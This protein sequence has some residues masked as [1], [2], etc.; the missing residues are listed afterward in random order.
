MSRRIANRGAARR[1]RS[2]QEND[3]TATPASH[4]LPALPNPNLC[5][6]R[7]IQSARAICARIFGYHADPTRSTAANHAQYLSESHPTA[8]TQPPTNLKSHNLCN[9]PSTVPSTL[10]KTLGL[11]LGFCLSLDRE[12]TNP[13]N[14]DRLRRD[15][16]TRY[17]VADLP[18][19]GYHPKLYVRNEEWEPGNAPPDVE[20]ALNA[21]ESRST[22][23]FHRSRLH[24]NQLSN[25]SAAALREI[26]AIKKEKK[27]MVTAT[28]KNL[29]PAIMETTLYIRRC[30]D[31]HLL[32][33][34]NYCELTETEALALNE[35]TYRRIL[36]HW[37]DDVSMDPD[38]R[39]YFERKL[40]GLRDTDGV[41]QQKEGL[42][43]QYFYIL[44]KVHKVPW[45]T[46]PVVSEVSSIQEALSVWI[47]VQLQ[48]V[49]HLCPAY[50]KDS[51]HF[52]DRLKTQPALPPESIIFTADAVGMYCNIN[53]DHA[54]DIMA[55]W[56]QLHAADIPASFP[57]KKVLTG[58]HIIMKSNVFTFGN[59]YWLQCNGTAMGTSCACAYATI[60]YSFHEET[61]LLPN[62]NVLFYGRLID[63]A[64]VVLRDGPD[65]YEQ[66]VSSMND[67]GPEG[68][69]LEWEAEPHSTTVN[70]LDLTVSLNPSG[71]FETSTFQKPM[72]LYLY[73]PPTSAQPDSILY[74]LVYG[75]LHRYFWQ[76]T[77]RSQFEHF[78]RLFFHRLR[79]RGHTAASLGPL[80]MKAG[81][82]V[83]KSARPVPYNGPPKSHSHPE[84]R[85][86]LHLP[87]HPKDPPRS[88][89][90][91]IF[92]DTLELAL[93]EHDIGLE[94]MTIAYSRAPNLGDLARRNRLGPAFDTKLTGH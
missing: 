85:F 87:F 77:H 65:T 49:L 88:A 67:F 36:L 35:H 45:K 93:T 64:F 75:T 6:E 42:Q 50:L 13:I 62:P 29:G 22:A 90:Q 56:F 20:A 8:L 39:R 19:T 72:N 41:I 47:D 31:D 4:S 57:R 61:R 91:A 3:P 38:S 86:F 2:S 52:L 11:G 15:I 40:C 16:R 53:T 55:Q 71:T 26:K 54:L 84:D 28:D 82:N 63:D 27:F 18:D 24:A 10:L 33:T 94:R 1:Y 37:I 73:R 76:N 30:L 21:F 83:E 5:A 48:Q 69:R 7:C 58:L 23:L 80:F 74:G 34:T 43:F 68:K 32:N 25:I 51:W 92:T 66:F 9:E 46:R 70:F 79:A 44:P 89:I 59:R 14:F 81:A 12:P 17:A 78:T 60:Y